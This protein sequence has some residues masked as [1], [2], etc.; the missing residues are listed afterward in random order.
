MSAFVFLAACAMSGAPIAAALFA[1]AIASTGSHDQNTDLKPALAAMQAAEE[2]ALGRMPALR[3]DEV[4]AE[5]YRSRLDDAL[6]DGTAR[7]LNISAD[8]D[9]PVGAGLVQRRVVLRFSCPPK[10]M[11][12]VLAAIRRS[13]PTLQ[14]E[15]VTFDAAAVSL[16]A[17]NPQVSVE[18]FVWVTSVG[19]AQ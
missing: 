3:S 5:L 10:E 17:P 13:V 14:V 19:A 2:E 1:Q 12:L 11:G 16:A 7:V 8:A 15:Q 4:R 18:G 9:T 6:R